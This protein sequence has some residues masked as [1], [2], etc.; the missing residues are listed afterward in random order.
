M[1]LRE[2]LGRLAHIRGVP[3]VTISLNTHRTHPD[4]LQDSILLK[5]LC[6]EAENKLIEAFDK[7]HVLPLIERLKAL[8][9]KIDANQNLESLHV[10][11]SNDIEEV[12]RLPLPIPDN[13]VQIADAFAVRPLIKAISRVEEHLIVVVSQSGAPLYHAVNDA[14]HSEIANGEFPYPPMTN[15]ETDREKLSDPK[16]I[17]NLVREYLNGLDKALNRVCNRT[18]LRCVVVATED[19]YSRLMQVADRKAIYYDGFVPVNY[20]QLAPHKIAADAW[21]LVS[22]VQRQERAKAIDEV[23]E[24]VKQGKVIT[25][26][27]EIYRAAKEGR[28]DLLVVYEHFKLPARITGPFSFEPVADASMLGVIDDLTGEIAWEVYAKKGRV[29]FT[30]QEAMRKLGDIALKV[31]Y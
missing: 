11:V 9:Q 14:I 20:N 16:R 26:L 31:R 3:C 19:N 17:D 25:D 10:F 18:G 28:G 24:A 13:S 30:E 29:V 5:N 2:Q 8:P 22:Q 12:V 23:I 21:A 6:A 7:K 27:Q 4:N 15:Q 1:A